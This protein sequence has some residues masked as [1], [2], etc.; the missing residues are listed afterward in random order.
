VRAAVSLLLAIFLL[1]GSTPAWA[2]SNLSFARLVLTVER[3]ER[4]THLC[5][6][7]R[8]GASKQT[9][10]M[11]ELLPSSGE[12]E[13]TGQRKDAGAPGRA[14]QPGT[15]LPVSMI[16]KNLGEWIF[17][18]QSEV[19]SPSPSVSPTPEQGSRP[20]ATQKAG[21][22]LASE[23]LSSLPLELVEAIGGL[24][25]QTDCSGTPTG[26]GVADGCRARLALPKSLLK[27]LRM[28][29]TQNTLPPPG[30]GTSVAIVMVEGFRTLPSVLEVMLT[31]TV[32]FIGFDKG[33]QADA[34]GLVATVLG[35]HY[36]P[37]NSQPTVT[38]EIALQLSPRCPWRALTLPKMRELPT[39]VT[40]APGW[41]QRC[42]LRPSTRTVKVRVPPGDRVEAIGH[43]PTGTMIFAAQLDDGKDAVQLDARDLHFSW[44]RHCLYAGPC[45]T[46]TP[47]DGGVS[48][49]GVP[50]EPGTCGYRCAATAEG[51]SFQLPAQLTFTG[52]ATEW[53][54]TL[55]RA[56]DVLTAYVDPS[57]RTVDI[58]PVAPH[59]PA[60]WLVAIGVTGVVFTLPNGTTVRRS[61]N[62]LSKSKP[63]VE[64]VH[65]RCGDSIEYQYEG[66][67]TFE[68]DVT[69]VDAGTLKLKAPAE[70][71]LS[72]VPRISVG[73]G[74]ARPVRDAWNYD[75]SLDFPGGGYAIIES[76][77]TVRSPKRIWMWE[78]FFGGMLGQ[79]EYGSESFHDN[80]KV[81][82][83]AFGRLFLGVRAGML[84]PSIRLP[85]I[86][87]PGFGVAFFVAG[88]C[89]KAPAPTMS[90]KL[91]GECFFMPGW[92]LSLIGV[93]GNSIRLNY[94]AVVGED[95]VVPSGAN[96]GRL[97]LANDVSYHW[98]F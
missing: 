87:L 45:P 54:T 42:E 23:M 94:R 75:Q 1:F 28:T 15:R 41:A 14:G 85:S 8:F 60:E 20:E 88:G 96:P 10:A 80:G 72:I 40:V 90:D 49:D 93:G 91:P 92:T 74:Y 51:G 98:S 52:A 89:G 77:F 64:A 6:V 12:A 36:L 57:Q 86:T 9:V 48:C 76:N 56:G 84:I 3:S 29:C 17:E 62:F 44:A 65:L 46:V 22:A 67:R 16:E 38:G 34:K 50:A 83:G 43:W 2:A 35:G 58:T 68:P 97:L 30:R 4:P 7:S 95:L 79:R 33:A 71:A 32:A 24:A 78:P 19:G 66:D 73:I 53:A 61:L 81:A 37:G 82:G 59:D 13:G 69:R 25:A 31:N 21:D 70:H 11:H 47:Q 18:T 39:T 26:Q 63:V 5:V 27:D 55:N